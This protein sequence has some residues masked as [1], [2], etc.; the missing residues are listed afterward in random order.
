M[1]VIDVIT[2]FLAVEHILCVLVVFGRLLDSVNLFEQLIPV[3]LWN[4]F[5]KITVFALYH[6]FRN[7][8]DFC[9]LQSIFD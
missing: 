6:C 4:I 9:E 2:E 8:I 7:V 5:R 1:F 3:F